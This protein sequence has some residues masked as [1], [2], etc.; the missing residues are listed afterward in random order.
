MARMT[1]KRG[2]SLI[3]PALWRNSESKQPINLSGQTIYGQVR[4]AQTGVLVSNIT[5]TPL[6]QQSNAGRAV[7]DFGATQD[8]PVGVMKFDLLR[9]IDNQDQSHTVYSKTAFITVEEG[10]TQRE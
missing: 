6:N 7:I 1:I 4:D 10:V 8:W 3:R 5:V 2:A 9:E